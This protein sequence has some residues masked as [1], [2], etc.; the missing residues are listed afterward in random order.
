M[1]CSWPRRFLQ[2]Y[3]TA[4]GVPPKRL[5]AAAAVWLRGYAW[6]GNVRELGHVMERVVLL[7]V[8]EEVDTTTVTQLCLPL[9]APLA[10]A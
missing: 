7:H 2:Q 6:P 1:S 9:A 4:H 10:G 3:T 8:G 5:S